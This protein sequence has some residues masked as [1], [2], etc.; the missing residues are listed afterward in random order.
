MP[1]GAERI[2]RSSEVYLDMSLDQQGRQGARAGGSLG[3]SAQASVAVRRLAAG[4]AD[5]KVMGRGDAAATAQLLV[6]M[7]REISVLEFDARSAMV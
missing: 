7:T 1:P 2:Y 5:L 4:V 6:A 3:L